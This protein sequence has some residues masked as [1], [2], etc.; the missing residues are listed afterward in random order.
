MS[1]PIALVLTLGA[2]GAG[3]S[4]PELLRAADAFRLP[5][6]EMQVETVIETFKK[7]ELDKERRYRVLVRPG[8]RS[9]VL[10]RSPVEKGQKVLMLDEDFWMILPSSQ[11]PMRITPAQKLLGDAAV[12]DIATMT[13]A[14]D[15][16]GAVA[17]EEAVE[18]EPCLRLDLKAKRKGVTYARIELVL[19]RR[20]ARPVKADLYVA[21]ERLAKRA[22]FT[23]E[24]VDGR[25]QVSAMAL[26][27]EIQ[28]SR[29]TVIRYLSRKPRSVADEWFNP[30]FL[31]RNSL[32]E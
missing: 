24:P 2:L 16:D 12:G 14:D 32:E 17:G 1:S 25:P 26:S 4:V 9:L 6:G 18:G 22:T 29:R 21:S 10:S 8:R 28:T 31:T 27:D 30:M 15:Y 3:S 13:W 7:G 19:A 23:V 20:D 5:D 11:R